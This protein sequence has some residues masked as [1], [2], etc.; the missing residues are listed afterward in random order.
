MFVVVPFLFVVVPFLY[1]L[2]Y[3]FSSCK[4][5]VFN[6]FL[7]LTYCA[8]MGV[9]W[10]IHIQYRLGTTNGSQQRKMRH[11]HCGVNKAVGVHPYRFHQ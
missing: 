11:I 10:L 6:C 2:Y 4:H 9:G 3:Y 1:F 5:L 7:I 8:L